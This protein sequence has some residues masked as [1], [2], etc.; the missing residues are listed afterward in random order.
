VDLSATGLAVAIASLELADRI[1]PILR[2]ARDAVDAGTI[3][4]EE[5]D[6]WEREMRQRDA[7]GRFFASVPGFAVYGTVPNQGAAT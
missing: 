4:P 7:E 1:E 5:A 6:V 2:M 3:S